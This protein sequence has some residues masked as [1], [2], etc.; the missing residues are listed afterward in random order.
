M[1]KTYYEVEVFR[2][3]KM[4]TI[5]AR[6]KKEAKRIACRTAGFSVYEAKVL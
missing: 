4:M 1:E 3:P 2:F 5:R 6:S